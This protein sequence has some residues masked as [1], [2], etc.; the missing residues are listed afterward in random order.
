VFCFCTQTVVLH[1][2]AFI[3]FYR[4]IFLCLNALT[5]TGDD[6]SDDT[7]ECPNEPHEYAVHT[8]VASLPPAVVKIVD[9]S[10]APPSANLTVGMYEIFGRT[11]YGDVMP[12]P[13]GDGVELDPNTHSSQQRV[14]QT[15]AVWGVNPPLS[16]L[17]PLSIAIRL[18]SR[19]AANSHRFTDDSTPPP[20][21]D[22][23]LFG[24]STVSGNSLV[25]VST[26]IDNSLVGDSTISDDSTVGNDSLVADST[27]SDDS[28]VGNDPLV[29]DST[30]SDDSLVPLFI[31]MGLA[32]TPSAPGVTD[33]GIAGTPSTPGVTN[34]GIAG[35]PSTPSVTDGGIAGT[36]STPGVTNGEIA[37]TPSTPGVTDGR[38]ARTP[39]TPAACLPD[40]KPPSIHNPL[41]YDANAKSSQVLPYP[42]PAASVLASTHTQDVMISVLLLLLT[43]LPLSK[44]TPTPSPLSTTPTPTH[45]SVT[46]V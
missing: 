1:K 43:L 13:F 26:V 21:T 27:V 23:S 14:F 42:F 25:D 46:K 4:A 16:N 5:F 31:A 20:L 7:V 38:I 12:S 2:P 28:T 45:R 35:T 30:V 29:A 39:S 6:G 37:G 3:H 17:V 9:A 44:S 41:A 8:I 40:S 19:H 18:D 15:P 33:G 22:N 11:I 10:L 36:P 24:D 34:G 32:G